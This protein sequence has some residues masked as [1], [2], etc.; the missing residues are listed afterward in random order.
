MNIFDYNLFLKDLFYSI[1]HL[2]QIYAMDDKP[3]YDR[4]TFGAKD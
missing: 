1:P 3:T 2:L 4:R